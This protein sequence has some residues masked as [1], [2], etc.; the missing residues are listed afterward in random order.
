[1]IYKGYNQKEIA[2]KIDLLPS[3]ICREFK[4]FRETN[5]QDYHPEHYQV[6][7]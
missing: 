7:A 5:K 4:I 6:K 1:L 3:T 2:N